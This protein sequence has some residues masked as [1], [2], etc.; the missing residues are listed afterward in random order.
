M[1][2]ALFARTLK[3]DP[4]LRHDF[5]TFVKDQRSEASRELESAA[6]D[7]AIFHAQGKIR[8]CDNLMTMLKQQM[9]LS[10]EESDG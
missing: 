6:A 4:E 2:G 9:N 7:I 5:E 8:M 3:Q 1:T 10:A